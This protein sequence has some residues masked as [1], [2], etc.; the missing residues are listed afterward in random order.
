MNA[1]SAE[2]INPLGLAAAHCRSIPQSSAPRRSISS[3]TKRW[4]DQTTCLNIS[5]QVVNGCARVKL[6]AFLGKESRQ[7]TERRAELNCSRPQTSPG[8]T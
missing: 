8:L 2:G 1:V 7:H 4:F 3:Q 6:V 5:V